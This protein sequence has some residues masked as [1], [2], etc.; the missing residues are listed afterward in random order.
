MTQAVHGTMEF[1]RS[2][3][4]IDIQLKKLYKWNEYATIIRDMHSCTQMVKNVPYLNL[5]EMMLPFLLT[6]QSLY[7]K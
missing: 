4:M 6:A 2:E 1:F 7:V 3:I 5:T